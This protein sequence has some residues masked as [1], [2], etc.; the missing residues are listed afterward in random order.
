MCTQPHDRPK[1]PDRQ[2]QEIDSWVDWYLGSY[3][4]VGSVRAEKYARKE[5]AELRARLDR[6]EA[7][8]KTFLAG[9]ED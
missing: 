8:C 9:K 6:A 7:A 1:P 3:G 5:L 4:G 2:G